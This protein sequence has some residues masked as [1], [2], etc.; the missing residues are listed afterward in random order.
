MMANM[1]KKY[2]ITEETLHVI[3]NDVFGIIQKIES[4]VITI[5]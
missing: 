1:I 3:K 4:H 5:K 2:D